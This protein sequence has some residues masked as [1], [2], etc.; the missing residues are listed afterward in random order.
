MKKKPHLVVTETRDEVPVRGACSACPRVTFAPPVMGDTSY[1]LA[2]L[3]EQ[4]DEHVK[5]AHMR[6]E[7]SQVRS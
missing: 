3:E 7:Q 5:K 6:E 1:N 4:F 2:M